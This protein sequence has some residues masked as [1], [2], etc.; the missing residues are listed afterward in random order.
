MTSM[1]E[2]A[3]TIEY[4]FV[5]N[6][7]DKVNVGELFDLIEYLKDLNLEINDYNLY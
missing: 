4:D 1:Q 6:S 2:D 7:N 5:S 3:S